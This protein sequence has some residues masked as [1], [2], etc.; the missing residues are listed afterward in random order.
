MKK[1]FLRGIPVCLLAVLL[2][3]RPVQGALRLEGFGT[4]QPD[5]GERAYD[6]N[7]PL[8]DELEETGLQYADAFYAVGQGK[9]QMERRPRQDGYYG[10]YNYFGLSDELCSA[11]Y[12]EGVQSGTGE[13]A[14][15]GDS[16][17]V[18]ARVPLYQENTG[19][20]AYKQERNE[21]AV[22]IRT[23]LNGF[24]WRTE[25]QLYRAQYA[26]LYI[27]SNCAYD[28]SL[29]ERF[30]QSGQ[31]DWSDPSFTAYGCLVNQKAVCQGI[32]VA[33]QLLTRA[34][35]LDSF[36]APDDND[37]EHMFVYVR[38]DGNWYKVDLAVLNIAP[39]DLV[40][41]CFKTTVNEEVSRTQ[42]A[43][44]AYGYGAGETGRGVDF[45]APG[46][47]TNVTMSRRVRVY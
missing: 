10:L 31:E 37:P 13:R 6:I 7:Y 30:L 46:N 42:Q 11:L 14:A 27:A 4:V 5:G 12:G 35:G 28:T 45:L 9:G 24:S 23:Y 20:A 33:Y 1:T 26:A 18:L 44:A 22:A 15:D 41:R 16:L 21:L 39:Q 29:Y 40:N 43:F 32:S 34:T 38:A 36:C 3:G 17:L 2:L 25:S 19:S 47:L 8:Q